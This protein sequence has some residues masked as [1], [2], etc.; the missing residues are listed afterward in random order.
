MI[1][2]MILPHTISYHSIPRGSVHSG[3]AAA[4]APPRWGSGL[5]AT[6]HCL[7]RPDPALAETLNGLSPDPFCLSSSAIMMDTIRAWQRHIQMFTSHSLL[8]LPLSRCVSAEA[9]PRR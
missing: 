8:R 6:P 1:M 7:C 3:S 4:L 5:A 9:C 2:R